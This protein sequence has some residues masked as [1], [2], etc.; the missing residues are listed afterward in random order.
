[1]GSKVYK[2]YGS[3]PSGKTKS[4]SY[5][6]THA[7]I[8]GKKLRIPC[9][10]IDQHIPDWINQITVDPERILAIQE[11]YQTAI[12]KTKKV[13]WNKKIAEAKRKKTLLQDEEA[14]LGRLFITGKMSEPTYDQLYKEWGEKLRQM[15]LNLADMEREA[16]THFDDLEVALALMSKLSTLF[17][18]LTLKDQSTLLQILV[19][20]IIVN[21]DGEII[22]YE[23]C[24]PFMYLDT[25]NKNYSLKTEPSLFPNLSNVE[26]K[27]STSSLSGVSVENFLSSIRF[28]KRELLD[29]LSFDY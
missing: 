24:S 4:F 25:I 17:P 11:I 6:I 13:D 29:N 14:R 21:P 7:K 27:K 26:M 28:E 9:K 19:K 10:R 15:E 20:Q 16:T 23:L 22:D 1:V 12:N 5:Y 2:L 18:R 8:K 3:T